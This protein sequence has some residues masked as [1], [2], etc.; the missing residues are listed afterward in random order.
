ML[1][2]MKE[3]RLHDFISMAHFFALRRNIFNW[4]SVAI[5]VVSIGTFSFI[6]VFF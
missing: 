4:N 3:D 5:L 6:I 1:V 2:E